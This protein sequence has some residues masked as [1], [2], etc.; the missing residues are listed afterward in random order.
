MAAQQAGGLENLDASSLWKL[1][2]VAKMVPGVEQRIR[3]Y[4]L[5]ATA[6]G[7]IIKTDASIAGPEVGCQGEICSASAM[8]AAGLTQVFGGSA[9]PVENAAEI[10]MEHS[11][12]LTCDP[13]GGLVQIPCIRRHAVGGLKAISAARPSLYR[14]GR[15]QVSLDVGVEAMRRTG[16]GVLGKYKETSVGGRAANT[17]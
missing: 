7:A 12:G 3:E 2:E 13:I 16:L 11:L 14:D 9:A 15:H 8:A 17:A 1:A 5:T 10:A 6:T 4:L